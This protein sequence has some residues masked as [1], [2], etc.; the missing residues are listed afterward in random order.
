MKNPATTWVIV[1]PT[2]V[3]RVTTELSVVEIGGLGLVDPALQLRVAEPERSGAGPV[4]HLRDAL[5]DVRPQVVDLRGQLLTDQRQH[6]EERRQ[7]RDDDD[8]R[9][10]QAWHPALDEPVDRA[11]RECGAEHGD[12]DGDGD[13]GEEAQQPDADTAGGCDEQQPP[14]PAGRDLDTDRHLVPALHV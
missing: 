1:A 2:A 3:M 6:A 14:G 9:G 13:L 11:D 8:E 12:G 5:D 4:L 10:Q 7:H